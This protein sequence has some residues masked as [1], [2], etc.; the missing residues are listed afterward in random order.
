M[1]GK[2]LTKKTLIRKIMQGINEQGWN[3]VSGGCG[4][5]ESEMVKLLIEYI[6]RSTDIEIK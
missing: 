6:E 5:S 4:R 2:T 1:K 3:L